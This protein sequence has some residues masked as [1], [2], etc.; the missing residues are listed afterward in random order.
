MSTT[1]VTFHT[2]DKNDWQLFSGASDIAPGVSPMV[3]YEQAPGMEVTFVL[4]GEGL[5]AFFADEGED[6]QVFMHAKPGSLTSYPLSPE[7]ATAAGW[8]KL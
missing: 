8:E 4:C 5:Q 7:E 6:F 1:T 3:A 2:F